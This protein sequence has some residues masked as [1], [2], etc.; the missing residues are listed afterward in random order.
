MLGANF[1]STGLTLTMTLKV[2]AHMIILEISH[3]SALARCTNNTKLIG[4][5]IGT[6]K[7]PYLCSVY[8][9]VLHQCL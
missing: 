6:Y 7:K 3:K 9:F 5:I 2:I 8:T 1:W 4:N